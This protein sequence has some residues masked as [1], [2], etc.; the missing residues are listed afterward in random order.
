MC[1]QGG[2]AHMGTGLRPLLTVLFRMIPRLPPTQSTRKCATPTIPRPPGTREHRQADTPV[3]PRYLH[4]PRRTRAPADDLLFTRQLTCT[5]PG[6]CGHRAPRPRRRAP[7]N[8]HNPDT[9]PYLRCNNTPQTRHRTGPISTRSTTD[10]EPEY[11]RSRRRTGPISTQNRTDLDT[12]CY[13]SRG[14]TGPIS[15]R[16]GGSAGD[17]QPRGPS[18]AAAAS[19]TRSFSSRVPTETRTPSPAKGRTSTPAAAKCSARRAVASPT[20]SQ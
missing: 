7:E 8:H 5:A 17:G 18:Q 14:G 20:P 12:G 15:T 10:L 16:G 11:D 9:H 3:R 13:R 1:G 19:S 6:A 2:P 4:R